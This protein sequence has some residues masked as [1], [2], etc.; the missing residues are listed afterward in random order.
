MLLIYETQVHAPNPGAGYSSVFTWKSWNRSIFF[1]D[2]VSHRI[3]LVLCLLVSVSPYFS[4]DY[5]AIFCSLSLSLLYPTHCSSLLPF[6]PHLSFSPPIQ[7]P[8]FFLFAQLSMVHQA[9]LEMNA[10]LGTYHQWELL[11]V[12]TVKFP[13][14]WIWLSQHCWLK[15]PAAILD[16]ESKGRVRTHRQWRTWLGHSGISCFPLGW[17]EAKNDGDVELGWGD[18]SGK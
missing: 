16:Q 3:C 11:S 1:H 9:Q 2:V 10:S 7:L 8:L 13:W 5:L 4:F 15:L 14:E 12:C 18:H 17:V 6:I